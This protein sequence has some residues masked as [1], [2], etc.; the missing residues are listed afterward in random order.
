[1]EYVLLKT[2]RKSIAIKVEPDLTVKVFAP[3]NCPKISIDEFIV[4]HEKWISR[5]LS[6]FESE[7][8]LN[9]N[10]YN[11]KH[12]YFLGEV[13]DFTPNFYKIYTN[14]AKNYLKNRSIQLASRFN[15]T[16]NEVKIKNFKR[17][18]GCC[19]AKN[20]ITLN[21]KLIFINKELIDYV[22]IHELCHTMHLNHSKI[23]IAC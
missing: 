9:I 10:F 4:K 22:I 14:Y 13:V 15:F 11:K 18:W 19:D 20:N 1:M 21:E 6:T 5:V 8:Q 23:F 17:K 7:Y 3:I 12:V 16:I 2:K